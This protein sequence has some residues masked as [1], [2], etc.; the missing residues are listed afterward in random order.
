LENLHVTNRN[1]PN[2][3]VGIVRD[4]GFRHVGIARRGGFR[5]VGIVGD[6]GFRHV[7]IVW[8]HGVRHVEISRARRGVDDTEQEAVAGRP[9]TREHLAR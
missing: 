2:R 6:G 1:S 5:H 8:D 9:D 3:H 7:G 4:G